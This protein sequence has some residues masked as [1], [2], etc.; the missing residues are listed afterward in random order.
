[1]EVK[2]P[3]VSSLKTIDLIVDFPTYGWPIEHMNIVFGLDVWNVLRIQD[4]TGINYIL[5]DSFYFPY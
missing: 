5:S 4:F 3:N 1:M 2:V